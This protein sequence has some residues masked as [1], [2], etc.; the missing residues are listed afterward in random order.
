MG[1]GGL[2]VLLASLRGKSSYI[3]LQNAFTFGELKPSCLAVW[4]MLVL[5]VPCLSPESWDQ[6][7]EHTYFLNI[8]APFSVKPLQLRLKRSISVQS[9]LNRHICG[10]GIKIKMLII[11]PTMTYLR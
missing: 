6:L 1:H 2:L 4:D 11:I 5:E 9:H 7:H 10:E 3:L 8:N